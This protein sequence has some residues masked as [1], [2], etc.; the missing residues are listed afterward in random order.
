M[1]YL[2]DLLRKLG[3]DDLKSKA[4]EANY[5]LFDFKPEDPVQKET[6]EKARFIFFYY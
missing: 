4:A 3:A 6:V 5:I 1:N 2:N